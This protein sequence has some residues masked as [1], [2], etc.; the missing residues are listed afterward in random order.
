MQLPRL[1]VIT[2]VVDCPGPIPL[3]ES[4]IVTF[5]AVPEPSLLTVTV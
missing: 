4:V 3:R 1:D 2:G 5:D